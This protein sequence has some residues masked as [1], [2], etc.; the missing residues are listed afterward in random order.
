MYYGNPS[1]LYIAVVIAVATNFYAYW[2]SDARPLAKSRTTG[3]EGRIFDFYTVT[4]NLAIAAGAKA[5]ALCDYDPAPNAF[6]TGRDE[7][8]AVVC[9]TTGLFR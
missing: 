3:L 8:H 2:A 1:I 5:E 4:E 6:A 9:A 7:H